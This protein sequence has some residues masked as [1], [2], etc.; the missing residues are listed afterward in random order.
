MKYQQLENLEA[1]WKW[2]Y[3]VKKWKEGVAITGYIDTSEAEAAVNDLLAIE[4]EPTRVLK[5]IDKHM[6]PD[7]DNKLKQAIRAKRKRHFNAEQVH[8]RKKSIDLDYRVWE[9]LAEK[10]KELDCTLSDTIEYLLS[11]SSKT[12]SASRKVLDIKNDLHEL[13]DFDLE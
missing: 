12:E 4:H 3:L 1:G 8:T 11:E 2:H 6:S 7:L 9:R 10:S 5:W 13:L